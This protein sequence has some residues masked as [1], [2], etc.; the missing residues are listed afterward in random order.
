LTGSAHDGNL[1]GVYATDELAQWDQGGYVH[2]VQIKDPFSSQWSSAG[3]AIDDSGMAEGQV[4]KTN[5][6]FSSWYYEIDM[7][8]REEGDYVFEIRAF[9]GIDYSPI[10]YRTV[11]LNVQA[12]TVSVNSPSPSSTHS[13]GSITFEGTAF[14]HYGCPVECSKDLEDIYFH[15]QGPNFE[16][17]TPAEGGAEWSWTWDF[18]GL[19]REVATYTFTIW[20]SDSDFCQGFIDECV[21]TELSLTIDNSNS[22]PFISVITPYDGQRLSVSTETIFE[23]VARDN[24]GSVSRVDFEI[25]DVANNFLVVISDSVS[26]FAPNG[27]WSLEWDSTVLMHDR[28]YLVRFRSYDGYDYS[29]WA[30]ATIIADNPPDAG[31]SQP[32]FDATLWPDEIILYCETNS[33]SQDRCTKAE[34]DLLQFFDD[35]DPGQELILSV[36]DNDDSDEDDHHGIVVNVGTDGMAIYNPVTMFFYD[37]DM[38]TWTLENVVFV[39]TDTFGSK[40]NSNPVTLTVQGIQFSISP[41]EDST[42]GDDEIAVFT[43]I[44]LPGKT[45]TVTIDGN[46]VNNTVVGEDSIWSLGVPASRIDGTAT[47]VFKYAGQDF[48]G[49]K[50]TV[51]GSGGG[52]MGLGSIALIAIVALALLGGLVYFFVEFEVDEDELIEGTTEANQ[53]ADEEEDTY[54]WAK[55]IVGDEEGENTSRLQKHDDHPGWLWDPDNQEWVPDPDHP[56]S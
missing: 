12:P 14:D 50:I 41:P 17:T 54:A 1:A 35:V 42:I 23:G 22:A 52:G 31:N 15:I 2:E 37:T 43:G 21:P 30:E 6:P 45:V 34:I 8:N 40:I 11:K 53:D 10:I 25:Q 20:A 7:S 44:G 18:S 24:D 55:D 29:D 28:Q 49:T 27:A 4:T 56:Q 38:S 26:D 3:L 5:R 32:T 39:A 48:D 16:V 51:S 46:N 47:P 9:D 13:E 19:P 36:Y 33:Q